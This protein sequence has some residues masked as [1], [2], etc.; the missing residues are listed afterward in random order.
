[1]GEVGERGHQARPL[2][3]GE[4]GGEL[5]EALEA[6]ADDAARDVPAGLRDGDALHAAVVLV[7]AALEV[8]ALEEGVD[9]PAG[10]GEREGQLLGHLLDRQLAAAVAEDLER[11]DVA[12][13]QVELVEEGEHR[14]AL[15]PHEVVPEREQLFGQL[16]RGDLR[17]RI[18]CLHVR[19]YCTRAAVVNGESEAVGRHPATG[20]GRWVAAVRPGRE[21]V[22]RRYAAGVAGGREAARRRYAAGVATAGRAPKRAGWPVDSSTESQRSPSGSTVLRRLIATGMGMWT[23]RPCPRPTTTSVRPAIAAWT[24]AW[25]SRTQ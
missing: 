5:L 20:G 2:L 6:G 25:A 10:A 13:R 11:L 18:A 12:H 14:L 3:G 1:M 24:A 16:R 23:K 19:K 21:P 4:R 15:P 9:R 7:L 22:R 17:R 8:T